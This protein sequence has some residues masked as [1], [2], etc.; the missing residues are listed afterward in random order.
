[1]DLKQPGG[2]ASDVAAVDD[3]RCLSLEI[4]PQELARLGLDYEAVKQVKTVHR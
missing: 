4:R 2:A 3:S 1:M